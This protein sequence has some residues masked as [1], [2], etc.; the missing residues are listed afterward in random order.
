MTDY[1]GLIAAAFSPMM[2]DGQINVDV[3]PGLLSI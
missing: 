2:E 1:K 3:I